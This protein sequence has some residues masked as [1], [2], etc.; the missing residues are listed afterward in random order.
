MKT[1]TYEK[2]KAMRLLGFAQ[3]LNEQEQRSTYADMDFEQR[4]EFLVEAEFL[5]RKNNR[6]N[7]AI[8]NARISA[9]ACIENLDYRTTRNLKKTLITELATGTW[10]AKAQNLI[11]TGPTGV[12][13]SFLAAALAEKACRLE[14]KALHIKVNELLRQILLAQAEGTYFKLIAKLAKIDVL[15]IDEWLRNPLSPEHAKEVLDV[16]D[17]RYGKLATVF[18][19]QLPVQN[20]HE[21]IKDPTAADAILDRI[22][23]NAHKIELKGE[24]LRKLVAVEK[25]SVTALR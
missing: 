24:S 12:G 19:S 6:I 11:I 9:Q 21:S 22:V 17:E 1:E 2:L 15:I 23:H 10:I 5:R 7:T 8:K 13:K 25:N 14:F 4:L 18:C 3:A 16:I 20:W